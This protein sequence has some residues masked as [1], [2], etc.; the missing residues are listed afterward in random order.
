MADYRI[1]LLGPD[2]HIIGV[3]IVRCESDI[4]AM[5]EGSAAGRLNGGVEI[6]Q[7]TRMVGR[8]GAPTSRSP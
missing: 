8:L 4:E 7:N 3:D 1:F 2:E 5:A 6:W